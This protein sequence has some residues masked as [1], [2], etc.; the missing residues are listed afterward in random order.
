MTA[1]RKFISNGS[2]KRSVIYTVGHIT[3]ATMCNIYITGALFELA[4]TDALI[5]PL[6]NGVWYYVL[7]GLIVNKKI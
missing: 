7:D 5:E 3:I 6:L 2:F 1:F 4:L